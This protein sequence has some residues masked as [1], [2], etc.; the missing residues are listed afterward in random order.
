MET[1]TLARWIADGWR[2]RDKTS[3]GHRYIT[4]LKDG[5]E[6][7]LGPYDDELWHRI[8]AMRQPRLNL[9]EELVASMR[10]MIEAQ[11]ATLADRMFA[12]KIARCPYVRESQG[13]WFCTRN[14]WHNRPIEL[15][16]RY[17]TVEFRHV[18][19]DGEPGWRFT[20]NPDTCIPCNPIDALLEPRYVE[21]RD[22]DAY[23]QSVNRLRESA[24]RRVT[25]DPCMHLSNGV[26]RKYT[27]S[28][29]TSTTTTVTAPNGT[30]RYQ[31]NV[32]VYAEYCSACPH[33]QKAMPHVEDVIPRT[34]W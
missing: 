24:D 26:C 30:I 19:I 12:I 21:R 10:A 2:F 14:T 17:P 32:S 5:V 8:Q 29:P 16:A 23:A 3:G 1:E 9:R 7:S 6:R 27:K 4:R 33:Y 31:L 34:R 13:R 28:E 11:D 15:I 22:F 25:Q 18:E 20:P